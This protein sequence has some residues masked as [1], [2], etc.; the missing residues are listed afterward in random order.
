MDSFGRWIHSLLVTVFPNEIPRIV[1]E[2]SN[3]E[4][5]YRDVENPT[6]PDSMQYY[7]D[8]FRTQSYIY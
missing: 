4:I 3:L 1:S 8:S 6:S 5:S 2:Y 7:D